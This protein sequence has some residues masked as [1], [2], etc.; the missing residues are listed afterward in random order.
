MVKKRKAFSLLW[1]ILTIVFAVLT[2]IFIVGSAI[3]N[4]YSAALHVFF[5]T[6]PYELVQIESD[7]NVDTE[8]FKSSFVTQ[9][10]NYDDEA[11][12][13]YDTRVA[14][15]IMNESTVMLWNN[16][17]ALPLEKGSSVSL[18][19]N[20]SVNMVYT[21][22]GSGALN[23][24]NAVDMKTAL[25]KY[26]FKVNDV[27]WNFYSTGAG[28]KKAGYGITQVGSGD[29]SNFTLNVKEVPWNVIQSNNVSSSFSEFNDA[30]IFVLGRSGGEGKDA[31]YTGNPDTIGGNYLE[32]TEV[33]RDV[34][35]QLVKAKEDGVFE[36]V[37]LL[38]NSANPMQ[39]K[40]ISEFND[41]IDACLWVG[42]PGVAGTPGIAKVLCGEANPS[43]RLIDTYVYDNGSAP[44]MM[45]FYS[46]S[47]TN[48]DDYSLGGLQR[49]YMIYQ[50]GIYIGYRY[51][52][53][54]YEDAVLNQ[55]NATS[56]AGTY[57]SLD[58]WDYTEEVTYPFGFG[59]SYTDYEFSE[60]DVKRLE[61]GDYEVKVTVTNVGDKA[62]REVAQ[63]Y[64][65]KPYT[66][67]DKAHGIE[68]S[69]VELV[70][71]AKT[72]ILDPQE[73]E[74]LT[75]IV[76][77]QDLKTYDAD[78]Y[79]TY[80]LEDG[81]YHF[82]IG[83]NA[84]DALNNILAKKRNDGIDIDSSKMVDVYGEPTTGN[85]DFVKS[86]ELEL[87]TEKY[88]TSVHTGYEITNQFDFADI[89]RSGEAGDQKITYLSR[90]DWNGTY[91]KE[92]FKL[93]LTD[94]MY[95]HLAYKRDLP[96]TA[97]DAE[98]WYKENAD[99]L[100][101]DG[102][103]KYGQDNGLS[104]IQM[105]DLPF[106]APE[107]DLLL[108]QM[109]WEEQALLCARGYHSTA[110]VSSINKPGTVDENGPCG[111][112]VTFSSLTSRMAM[113]WPSACNRGAT[114]NTKLNEL[115]GKC[116]GEDMLHANV[117]GCLGFGLNMHR[118]AYGARNFEYYSEDS[119]LSGEACKYETIGAQSK[120]AN[121]QV[122][123]FV[124]NDFDTIRNGTSTFANEQTIREIYCSPFETEFTEGGAWSTMA[125][126]ARIGNEWAGGC[127]NLMTNVLRREWGF[128]GYVSSDY[129]ANS[130]QD[131]NTYIGIQAGCDTYDAS[132][133][134][135]TQY[136]SV[137]GNPIFEYCLRISS[138]RICYA[139]LH[140]SAM[141]GI[142]SSTKV[143]TVNAWWQNVL[144]AIQVVFGVATLAFAGLL[145]LSIFRAR[146]L[147]KENITNETSQNIEEVK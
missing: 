127:Y 9:S 52:E 75:I 116:F 107:W 139:V 25:E 95:D 102:K 112:S 41:T 3:A 136:D 144:I 92:Y 79:K 83:Y 128:L 104:L 37:I 111:V 99:I 51:Y 86:F 49:P 12:W 115:M 28:S 74:T 130:R 96:Q 142:D 11:L 44:A 70:G 110:E 38:I 30:A 19:S 84:H 103:I 82:A 100:D 60:Y 134:N 2:V 23:T 126:T 88:S 77:D 35:N 97:A 146:K 141:N 29:M 4:T 13:D 14:E 36:K 8:Y 94:Q 42:V 5:N 113:G 93:A 7:E 39:M 45:N 55:G 34:L 65:Q 48:A 43:G 72:K 119:F 117:N 131:N 143:I 58:D 125:S 80:I 87:D 64:L 85:A 71:Y 21:G 32:L 16:S 89:N 27:L 120:G 121:I 40:L 66:E 26:E 57:E 106:D 62:G 17:D 6:R 124:L 135:E 90:N 81:T 145:I 129:T 68:K 18:F 118:T 33:E 133:F 105:K 123:H 122:K 53:T 50:E 91:P 137:K 63:V 147:A 31:L 10:G 140:T 73:S 59:L 22:S 24:S 138:K 47:W 56:A 54:R 78:G 98:A 109:S 1:L 132:E 20:T 114:F 76:D 61:D 46:K 101:S 15:Q 69:A 67:Y 108:D